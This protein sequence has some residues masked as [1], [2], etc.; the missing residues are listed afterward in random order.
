VQDLIV[1]LNKALS[2]EISTIVHATESVE[3]V[4]KAIENVFPKNFEEKRSYKKQRLTGHYGNPIIMVK[5]KI[6]KKASVEAF[7]K[8]LF[9]KI[10][11]NDR[12]KLLSEFEKHTDNEGNFYI[13]IDKQEAFLGRF[14]LKQ[15]DPIRIKIKFKKPFPMLKAYEEVNLVK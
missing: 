3:K 2:I 11:E 4:I 7:I 1:R 9:E 12:K 8:N 13:R 5:T 15:S 14:V 10:S 6:R